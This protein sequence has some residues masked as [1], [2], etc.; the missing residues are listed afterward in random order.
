MTLQNNS[1]S[2]QELVSSIREKHLLENITITALESHLSSDFWHM[3]VRSEVN[4]ISGWADDVDPIL[5]LKKAYSEY[6]ERIAYSR[7]KMPTTNGLAAAPLFEMAA[8]AGTREVIERDALLITWLAKRPPVWLCDS[9]ISKLPTQIQDIHSELD[10]LGVKLRLGVVAMSTGSTVT[11]AAIDGKKA[12]GDTFGFA[13]GFSANSSLASAFLSC[14]GE[15]CRYFAH[16]SARSRAGIHP[17]GSVAALV[18]R[19]ARSPETHLQFHLHPWNAPEDF[20]YW[21]S[22]PNILCLPELSI[23]VKTVPQEQEFFGNIVTVLAHSPFAQQPFWGFPTI[24]K[25]NLPRFEM[26]GLKPILRSEI[27]P[28]A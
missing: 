14:V 1:T 16:V 25:L 27:H 18:S 10:S 28:L 19:E 6:A 15:V 17:S 24:E 2:I 26:C 9:D 12:K 8:A 22:S 3:E 7:W 11:V 13:F 21:K 23:D 5:A 4:N 20:W